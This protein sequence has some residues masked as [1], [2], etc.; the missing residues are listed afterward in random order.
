MT[1]CWTCLVSQFQ[2]RI[3]KVSWLNAEELLSFQSSQNE[4]SP[5]EEHEIYIV[6]PLACIHS[7]KLNI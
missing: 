2:M 5:E 1:R 7:V 4:K 6:V 3:F